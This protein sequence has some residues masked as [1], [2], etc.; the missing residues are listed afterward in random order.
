MLMRFPC[1][2]R[3]RLL[4]LLLEGLAREGSRK[5]TKG[6]EMTDEMIL[7]FRIPF[8]NWVSMIIRAWERSLALLG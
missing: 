2:L 3:R 6:N 8:M 7:A 5:G 4:L 1:R